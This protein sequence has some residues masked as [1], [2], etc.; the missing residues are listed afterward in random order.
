MFVR[1]LVFALALMALAPLVASTAV[2]ASS[3]P[4][5][6]YVSLGD[7]IAFLPGY[8]GMYGDHI[9][10]DLGVEVK[11]T[12]LGVPGWRSADLRNALETR[13]MH[14]DAVRSADVVTWD[15]GINDLGMARQAYKNGNC[16]GDDGQQCLRDAVALFKTNWDAILVAFDELTADRTVTLRTFDAYRAYIDQD[17][18]DGTIGVFTPYWDEV[19]AHI[20]ATTPA[21]GIGVGQVYEAFNGVTGIEDANAKGYYSEDG[22][23]LSELGSTVI[24]GL[25]RDLNYAPFGLD[26]DVD[27]YIDSH[28]NCPGVPNT[29]QRN[30][31]ED[32]IDLS[33]YGKKF[34]DVT[35]PFSDRAGDA[36]DDDDDND[37]LSDLE[38]LSG[39]RC[40]GVQTSSVLRDTDGDNALDGAECLFGTDPTSAASFPPRVPSGDADRDGLPD[41]LEG[42]LGTNPLAHDTDGDTVTD[43]VEV[44]GFNSDPLASDTD[45]DGCEDRREIASVNGD[46]LVNVF[47]IFV[48][49][50]A[51]GVTHTAYAAPFDLNR[52][53]TVNVLD[54]M[55]GVRQV[56][57]CGA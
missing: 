24:S 47:D 39:E 56:G 37:G 26:D 22:I 6:R 31:D 19:N 46:H 50:S 51:A 57:Y 2:P 45:S 1:P 16:G 52:D 54:L 55:F 42:T 43:G 36:C 7:S 38:E 29:D 30:S 28:D 4:T 14:R 13:D 25:L 35:W 44:R 53:N 17:V 23:H 27:R 20:N 5:V 12:M 48:V 3:T 33:G 21:R 41:A 49:A 34:N 10:D 11:H 18:A 8:V 15:I 9:E 40:G 32:F